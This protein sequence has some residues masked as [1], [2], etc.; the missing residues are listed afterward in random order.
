MNW[1]TGFTALYEVQRVN[2]ISWRDVGSLDLIS[3]NISRSKGGLIESADLTMTES[4][5]ECW[6]RVYLKAKQGS[7][8][9]RVALFTGLASAP[10]RSLNGNNITHKVECYSVLKPIDDVLLPRGY[11]AQAGAPAAQAAAEL[12]SIGPAPV[13]YDQ[14]SPSLG[15]SI[16]AEDKDSYLSLAQKIVNAIGWSISITGNGEIEIT[17]KPDRVSAT[18]DEHENDCIEVS[19][20]DKN[21]WYSVPNCLRVTFGSDC[22]VVRDTNISSN[23]SIPSRQSMRGGTGE[24]WKQESLSS[25][26]DND[27]LQGYAERRLKELQA[28]AR[29]ISYSRRFH[30]DVGIGDKIRLHLPGRG[31]DDV[32]VVD[33]QKITLGYNAKVSEEVSIA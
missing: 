26:A 25:L 14:M 32:F 20:T 12:L 27:T 30:P 7:S 16:V 2:P 5:G 18:F 8:G 13:R 9:A 31:I 3:G 21:D 22:V 4:P 10:Q 33:S 6:V 24:I 23:L 19:I 28:P 29:K 11:F 15:T 1:N 17:E